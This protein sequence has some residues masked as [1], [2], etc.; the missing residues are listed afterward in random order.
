MTSPE[1][2]Q[3]NETFRKDLHDSGLFEQPVAEV[4]AAWTQFG[5]SIPVYSSEVQIEAVKAGSVNCEWISMPGARSD[6][7][8]LEF[9][10]GGYVIGNPLNTRNYNARIS[11]AAGARVLGVDYRLAPEHPFPAA[12]EDALEAYTWVLNQGVSADH[13]GLT[14]ESAGGGLAMATLLAAKAKGLPLPAAVA[15]VSPWVDLTFSGPSH[16]GNRDTEVM[17]APGL[18]RPWAELY[19]AG[20]D[21]RRPLAS[22]IFGELDGLPPVY[23]LVGSGEILLDDARMLFTALSDAGVETRIEVTNNVPHVWPVFAYRVPE[24]RAAI[25]RM[26]R[27]FGEHLS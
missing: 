14:G 25:E 24:S 16:V 11:E 12:V 4:R 20:E 23:I 26:A 7:V 8:I 21:P 2:R 22:A 18:L 5:T 13:V 10:G 19:L 27:F 3:L 6:R 1:L 9:H 15:A 17:M